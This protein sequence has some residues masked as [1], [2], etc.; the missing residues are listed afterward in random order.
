ML[1][2]ASATRGGKG[3]TVGQA[4]MIRHLHRLTQGVYGASLVTDHLTDGIE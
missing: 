1:L 2:A 4:V 3:G